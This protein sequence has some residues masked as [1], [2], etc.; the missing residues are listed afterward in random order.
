MGSNVASGVMGMVW[1]LLVWTA[2]AGTAMALVVAC[3]PAAEAARRHGSVPGT[4]PAAT[5]ALAALVVVG[6]ALTAF[7]GVPPWAGACWLVGT[8]MAAGWIALRRR[9][10][11]AW[12]VP[13]TQPVSG[14]A[15]QD[16][17]PRQRM[18]PD[19]ADQ[20]DLVQSLTI[21]SYA[22]QMGDAG[23][24][25]QAVE[26]ALSRSRA[27]LDLLMRENPGR[28]FVRSGPATSQTP[29]GPTAA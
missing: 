24:A 3:R 10:P 6:L 13:A 1:Q 9:D 21:A 28:G 8:A 12:G 5:G 17:S 16:G 29:A 19:L 25:H 18:S 4:V 15:G 14:D 2:G 27:T 11:A 7:A 20:D 23:R 22:L 26:V